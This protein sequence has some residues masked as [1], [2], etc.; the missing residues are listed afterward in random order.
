MSTYRR[1]AI[2]WAKIQHRGATVRR[3]SRSTSRAVAK[4]Y[5]KTLREEMGKLG[6]GGK[7]RRSFEDAM[8]ILY[9]PYPN[10]GI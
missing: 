1:G 2:W 8:A 4:A 7:P 9:F 6:H 10:G 5:E 3:S